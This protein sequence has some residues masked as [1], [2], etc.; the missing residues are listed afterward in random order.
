MSESTDISVVT[1]A[2][3]EES[4]IGKCIDSVKTAGE[5]VSASVE[6]II[7]LNRCTD[8]T[9]EIAVSK[10]CR[11][12]HQDARNLSRI[13]NT[14]VAAASGKIIVTID[15]DSWMSPNMLSEVERLLETG[16]Y[17]GG[18]VKVL[19][20]R[21]SLGIIGSL[22]VIIPFVLWHGGRSAGMFWCY[23]S[24]FDEL[25]G[26]DETLVCVEDVDF[27]K[28]LH[29]LGKK[30]SKRY[31]TVRRAVMTTSCR[32]FDEFGDW[33]FVRNPKAVYDIFNQD[34]KVADEF[35]Y[36]FTEDQSG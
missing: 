2:H 6:H 18:G 25:G 7:V 9:E 28:R 22:M 26:F 36:D 27:A 32:K 34:K 29:R 20:E 30:K 8:L 10:G 35:Y 3:N 14:G 23:K 16:R 13:R 19:P 12:V 21:W 17:V 5:N 24:D 15:A 11:V 1:P 4:H 33:Y 31:G